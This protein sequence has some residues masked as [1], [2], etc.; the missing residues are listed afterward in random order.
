MKGSLTKKQ[1]IHHIYDEKQKHHFQV[2][3]RSTRI[4][5]SNVVHLTQHVI[6]PEAN[7]ITSKLFEFRL[8]KIKYASESESAG[9]EEQSDEEPEE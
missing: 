4:R 2:Y 9:E 5:V 7:R 3:L 1:L 8:N 6:Q